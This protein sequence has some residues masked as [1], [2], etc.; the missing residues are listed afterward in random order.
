MLWTYMS[1]L[2][3]NYLH[4]LRQELEKDQWFV[5]T[6]TGIR[7]TLEPHKLCYHTQAKPGKVT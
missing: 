5:V 6:L 7:A 3:L 1:C 2:S 4:M